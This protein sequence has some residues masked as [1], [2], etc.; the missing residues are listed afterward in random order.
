VLQATNLLLVVNVLARTRGSVLLADADLA[1]E[2]PFLARELASDD[3]R[4]VSWA[5]ETGA[6]QG[7]AA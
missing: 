3:P 7:V 4:L 5:R 1:L 6:A 2:A